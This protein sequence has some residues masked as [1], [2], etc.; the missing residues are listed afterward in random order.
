M[1]I[2][3]ESIYDMVKD[4]LEARVNPPPECGWVID[5]SSHRYDLAAA[6]APIGTCRRTS[7][8]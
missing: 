6:R 8:V 7:S 5:S 1:I 4:T 2:T 3:P